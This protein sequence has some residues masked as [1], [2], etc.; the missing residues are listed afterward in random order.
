MMAARPYSTRST[1]SDRDDGVTLDSFHE[2]DQEPANLG[3]AAHAVD[4]QAAQ[5]CI[6]V[7]LERFGSID[8]EH[9]SLRRPGCGV[10][11]SMV[12][13]AVV[14]A[15]A[16]GKRCACNPSRHNEITIR[17]TG[18][19]PYFDSRRIRGKR[20]VGGRFGGTAGAVGNTD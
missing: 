17:S 16:G 20:C 7:T 6:E 10:G 14:T 11:R 5:R 19:P 12:I 3:V 15:F 8:Q 13:G 1:V 9:A 18:N 2:V 4:E